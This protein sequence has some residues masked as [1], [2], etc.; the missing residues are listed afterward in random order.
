MK[1]VKKIELNG[2]E[3]IFKLT[4]RAQIQLKEKYGR[5][6]IELIRE[7]I[8]TSVLAGIIQETS[9]KYNPLTLD[10]SYDFID[11]LVDAG[12]FVS[13]IDRIVFSTELAHTAGLIPKDKLEE[14]L[15]A[16]KEA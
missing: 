11:E 15:R 4:S 10:E 3:Y 2:K 14:T 16:L 5:D 6:V 1:N 12:V 8:D 13:L 7:S 9:Q